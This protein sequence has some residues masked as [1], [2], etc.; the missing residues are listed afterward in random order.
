MQGSR[1]D[2]NKNNGRIHVSLHP[3]RMRV[4]DPGLLA[5]LSYDQIAANVNSE[6]RRCY[7]RTSEDVL[8]LLMVTAAAVRWYAQKAKI[9]AK[10]ASPLSG[11]TAPVRQPGYIV[12]DDFK[13]KSI[14][15]HESSLAIY[16]L[17]LGQLGELQKKAFLT[18]FDHRAIQGYI[19]ELRELLADY[20]KAT[21]VL[22]KDGVLSPA[23]LK[24]IEKVVDRIAETTQAVIRMVVPEKVDIFRRLWE[25]NVIQDLEVGKFIS[26]SMPQDPPAQD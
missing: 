9:V 16:N 14:Q 13:L 3:L 10:A 6:V 15:Y 8:S 18:P 25:K 12:V 2:S 4:V 26:L 1:V 19:R 20:G 21:G 22:D 23:M 5:G 11:S 7:P 17:I 24:V